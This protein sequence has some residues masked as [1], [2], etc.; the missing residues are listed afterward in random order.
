MKERRGR[1][2]VRVR[3]EVGEPGREITG[4]EKRETRRAEGRERVS[5]RD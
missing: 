3:E 2:V 1:Q 4:V 5:E